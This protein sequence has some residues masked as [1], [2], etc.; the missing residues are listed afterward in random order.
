MSTELAD[1]P[2]YYTLDIAASG[3]DESASYRS[4]QSKIAKK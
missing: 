3:E 4:L 2:S 1:S